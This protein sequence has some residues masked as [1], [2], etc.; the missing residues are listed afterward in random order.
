MT[1]ASQAGETGSGIT[2]TPMQKR[3]NIIEVAF[4][5]LDN[6]V[7]GGTSRTGGAQL[8][9]EVYHDSIIR[10]MVATNQESSGYNSEGQPL[11]DITSFINPHS[12]SH[13][14][15]VFQIDTGE[16]SMSPDHL[17][18]CAELAMILES[19]RRRVSRLSFEPAV[20]IGSSCRRVATAKSWWER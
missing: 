10:R 13:I 2:P 18:P 14:V 3:C 16:S 17:F 8:T 11:W 19:K 6:P 7:N 15:H 4:F 9:A 1:P 20:K 5:Q 12:A